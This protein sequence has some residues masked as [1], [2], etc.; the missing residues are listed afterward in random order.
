MR[1]VR[2]L[3]AALVTGSMT[4]GAAAQNA[5]VTVFAAGSLRAP[6]TEA[7]R[8]FEAT[9][10]AAPVRFVF[11]ASGLLRE[12][13]ARGEAADVFASANME[14]PASLVQAGGFAPVRMFARNALCALASPE[15]ALA[16][17]NL[18]ATLLDPK[19]RVG[20]S[21]PK[22]DPSGDYAFEMFARI[23]A[24]RGAPPGAR[25]V[26]EDKALQLTGGPNSPAPPAD[27]SVYGMLVVRG[28]A[29]VF[30]TYCTNAVAAV[31]EEPRLRV[32]QIPAA[33]NVS[34][35]Y[36]LTVREEASPAAKAFAEYLLSPAGRQV[37]ARHGF[38]PP[39]P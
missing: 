15:L 29:D 25:R 24:E 28:D 36:G 35:E 38:H 32:V 3:V 11:G 31:A 10:G 4:A 21:T 37:L 33:I 5:A 16:E 6:L 2:D 12:R 18:V 8:A 34:A 20:T 23:G 30:I 17:S 26:L 22:A 13:L 9:A 7:A 39:Q 1:S 19:V 27:R 14:H